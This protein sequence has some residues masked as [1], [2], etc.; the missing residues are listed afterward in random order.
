MKLIPTNPML[1]KMARLA[2]SAKPRVLD[3][4]SGCGGLSLGFQAAGFEIAAAVEIDPFAARSHALNFGTTKDA[5]WFE[6][7]SK[8]IDIT[9]VDPEQLAK[10][11][12]FEEPSS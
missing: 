3:L 6:E 10:K 8:P 7:H 12:G 11:F 5:A 9:K 1:A 4:F 2:A